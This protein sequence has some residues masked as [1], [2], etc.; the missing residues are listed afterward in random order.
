M[1]KEKILHGLLYIGLTILIVR[2]LHMTYVEWES[3]NFLYLKNYHIMMMLVGNLL[4]A[5]Y[6]YTHKIWPL[7]ILNMVSI[8]QSIIYLTLIYKYNREDILKEEVEED[9]FDILHL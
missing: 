1:E 8:L 3:K 5:F 6:S 7:F 2:T 9:I 4:V